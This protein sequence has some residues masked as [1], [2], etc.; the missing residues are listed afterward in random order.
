MRAGLKSTSATAMGAPTAS[1]ITAPSPA[2]SYGASHGASSFSA[3]PTYAQAAPAPAPASAPAAVGDDIC[4]VCSKKVYKM[5]EVRVDSTA[6]ALVL[7]TWCFRC[8]ECNGKLSLGK[9]A[10]VDGVVYCKPH[11][12]QL[13]SLKGNYNEGFGTVPRKYDFVRDVPTDDSFA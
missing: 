5:E 1:A 7:H 11:F 6:G 3:I 13:F 9:Y 2:P 12:K 4:S 10:A 8:H